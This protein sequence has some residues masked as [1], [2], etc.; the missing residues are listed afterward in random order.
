MLLSPATDITVTHICQI[1]SEICHST[2]EN[3]FTIPQLEFETNALTVE[4]E[5]NL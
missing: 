3:F 1:A 2:T 4:P 5:N